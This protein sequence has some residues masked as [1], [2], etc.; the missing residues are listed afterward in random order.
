M[1]DDDNSLHTCWDCGYNPCLC[2]NYNT[3]A[4]W[5]DA[6]LTEAEIAKINES[7][8]GE[9]FC[10]ICDLSEKKCQCKPANK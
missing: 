6:E 3:D 8:T 4:N 10:L 7:L 1:I 2:G 9:Y 5:L